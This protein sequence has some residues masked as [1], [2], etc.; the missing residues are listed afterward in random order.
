MKMARL[1]LLFCLL[2]L[3]F[4]CELSQ[5]GDIE[6]ENSGRWY[7]NRQVEVGGHLYSQHCAQCHGKNGEGAPNWRKPEPDGKYPPPPLNGTGH[8]WHHPT[9]VLAK[10]IREGSPPD[11][12]KMPAWGDKLEQEEIMA[13]IAWFQS[14]WTDEIYAAWLRQEQRQSSISPNQG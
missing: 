1:V 3:L 5:Q 2:P 9:Q 6:K 11:L 7:L 12:G 10:V 8:A 13:V 14:H 4:G